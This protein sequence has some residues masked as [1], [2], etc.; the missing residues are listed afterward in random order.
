MVFWE[1]RKV[2]KRGSEEEDRL[3]NWNEVCALLKIIKMKII[4]VLS[5][6]PK[7]EKRFILNINRY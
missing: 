3:I 1:R 6:V 7:I 2:A 4:Y 5:F